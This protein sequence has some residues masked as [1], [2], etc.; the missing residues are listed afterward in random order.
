MQNILPKVFTAIS[1]KWSLLL[2]GETTNINVLL[3][4]W[5]QNYLL[6]HTER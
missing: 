4:S 5:L 2:K 6:S 1:Y 3:Q